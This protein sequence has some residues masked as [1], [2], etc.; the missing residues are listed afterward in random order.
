MTG[1]VASNLLEAGRWLLT[2]D[3]MDHQHGHAAGKLLEAG[4]WLLNVTPMMA[5]IFLA[6]LFFV[7]LVQMRMPPERLRGL[8]QQRNA[9]LRYGV[10]AAVGT[11][12]P[13]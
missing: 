10:G 9:L 7:E 2:P 12:T 3:M 5:G 6:V 8:F 11:A 13:F 4:R 1:D